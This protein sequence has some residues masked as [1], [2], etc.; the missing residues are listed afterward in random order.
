M[1]AGRGFIAAPPA[2]ARR[3]AR[4]GNE[5]RKR[6]NGMPSSKLR[7]DADDPCDGCGGRMFRKQLVYSCP[8]GPISEDRAQDPPMFDHYHYL[9]ALERNLVPPHQQ[10]SVPV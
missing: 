9:C 3:S 2:S 5:K 7:P 10:L 8:H 6:A 4:F 1:A